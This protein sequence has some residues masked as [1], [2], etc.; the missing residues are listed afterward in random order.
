[1]AA[2][3]IDQRRH[4]RVAVADGTLVIGE[5]AYRLVNWSLEG[6]LAEGYDGP[7]VTGQEFA[8]TLIVR[9]ER[10]EVEVKGRGCVVRRDPDAAG[11][12]AGTWQLEYPSPH[13]AAF[14]KLFL[15][16]DGITI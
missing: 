13:A 15:N 9:S 10:G 4:P 14:I 6:F 3:G 16:Y 5:S 7:L 2:P 11:R 1:M 12:V 8:L